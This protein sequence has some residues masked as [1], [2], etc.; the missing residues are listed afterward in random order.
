MIAR[1]YEVKEKHKTEAAKIVSPATVSSFHK[2]N[3]PHSVEGLRY[4]TD[5]KTSQFVNLYKGLLAYFLRPETR[6]TT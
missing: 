2:R 4:L 5:A 1:S 6:A 3:Q